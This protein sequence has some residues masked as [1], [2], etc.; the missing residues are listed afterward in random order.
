MQA[1]PEE[2]KEAAEALAR[3]D[4]LTD[5]ES[6]KRLPSDQHHISFKSCLSLSNPSHYIFLVPLH[7]KLAL[8]KP[9]P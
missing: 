1:T 9:G 6:R 2:R 4:M 5:D 7:T 8:L 3:Y